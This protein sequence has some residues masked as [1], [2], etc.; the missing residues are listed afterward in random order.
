LDEV[1]AL[2]LLEGAERADG[3]LDVLYVETG[4]G[5]GRR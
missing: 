3:V 5:R 1:D 4:H 2:H